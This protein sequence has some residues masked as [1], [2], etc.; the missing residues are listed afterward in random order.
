MNS[1]PPSSP[2]DALNAVCPYYTMFPL[3][4]PLRQLRNAKR[5]DWVLDPFCGRGTTVLAARKLGLPVVGVD[6]NPVAAAIAEAKLVSVSAERIVTV[7]R[8]LIEAGSNDEV[9][10][11]GLFWRLCF[12]D[13]TLRALLRLRTALLRD[14][15][16][17]ARKALRAILLGSLHGPR[18]KGFP[19]YFSNQMPRT[20][21]AKPDYAVRYWQKHGLKPIDVDLVDLVR[22]KAARYY[23]ERLAPAR[24]RIVQ[25]DSRTGSLEGDRPINWVITSPPYYGMRTYV[26]DQWLRSWF[27]GGPATVDYSMEGQLLHRSADVFTDELATVWNNVARHCA[28]RASMVV[29]FGGI[30]DRDVEPRDL[31]R[32]SIALSDVGWRLKTTKS[33]GFATAGK[34][35]AAQ[36]G[37]SLKNGVEE[38]DFHLRL[39]G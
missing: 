2:L 7:C 23:P 37:E 3:S 5:N 16:T 38:F 15:R 21:A 8:E 4:F 30:Q 17:P 26:P 32:R 6:S 35:Q 20:Y 18:N 12:T 29:R 11:R 34:R 31:L 24:G 10:P 33:A 14:C 9:A 25:A 13:P 36:F 22:R 28:P 39:E 1:R 19:S 27:L